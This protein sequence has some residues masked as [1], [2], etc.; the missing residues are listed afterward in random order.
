MD[1]LSRLSSLGVNAKSLSD[2]SLVVNIKEVE[3][4]KSLTSNHTMA[5]NAGKQDVEIVDVVHS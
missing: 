4:G 1:S 5:K 2:I 3:S